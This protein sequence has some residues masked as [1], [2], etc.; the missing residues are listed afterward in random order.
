MGYFP[1]CCHNYPPL[2]Y[3]FFLLQYSFIPLFFTFSDVCAP[4]CVCDCAEVAGARLWRCVSNYS[5]PEP[6]DQPLHVKSVYYSR[7]TSTPAHPSYSYF[8]STL[9]ASPTVP[10]YTIHWVCTIDTLVQCLAY[11]IDMNL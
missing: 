6:I 1:C 7:L 2:F 9:Q 4:V 5:G 3:L 11:P 8:T 10:T